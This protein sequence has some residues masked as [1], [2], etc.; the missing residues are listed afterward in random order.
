MRKSY[1][2]GSN[3]SPEYRARRYNNHVQ[4][5]RRNHVHTDVLDYGKPEQTYGYGIT[6][7]DD[8]LAKVSTIESK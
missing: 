7:L 5:K 8:F 2:T 1:A 4:K 6:D 3:A